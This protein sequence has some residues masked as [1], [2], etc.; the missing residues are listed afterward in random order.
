MK[1]FFQVTISEIVKRRNNTYDKLKSLVSSAKPLDEDPFNGEE[2]KS[3][4]WDLDLRGGV[5]E[6]ILHICFLTSSPV[7]SALA[8]RLL[9]CYP[10]LIDDLYMLDEYYGLF[11]KFDFVF[12]F[13]FLGENVLHIAIV[14]EEPATVKFLLDAGVDFNQRCCGKFFCPEDQKSS[15]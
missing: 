12:Y 8:K 14:N 6:H 1:I 13:K 7:H 11:N 10:R 2:T 5:G 15:R 4:C 3:V 9:R